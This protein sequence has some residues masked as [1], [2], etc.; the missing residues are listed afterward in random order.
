MPTP[1]KY[2]SDANTSEMAPAVSESPKDTLP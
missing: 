1:A 2:S